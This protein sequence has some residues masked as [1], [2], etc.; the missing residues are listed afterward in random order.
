LKK[1][2][3]LAR[4]GVPPMYSPQAVQA[5]TEL[6][7]HLSAASA[8]L[9][10]FQQL[11][12]PATLQGNPPLAIPPTGQ[13][14]ALR[15]ASFPSPAPSPPSVYPTPPSSNYNHIQNHGHSYAS[16]S[17]LDESY[18]G[19]DTHIGELSVSREAMSRSPSLDSACCGGFLDCTEL[20]EEEHDELQEDELGPSSVSLVRTSGM[21]S[22][23]DVINRPA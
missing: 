6:L 20:V 19:R 9:S 2:L 23:S 14:H 15:P 13:S 12:F 18:R 16:Q 10:H 1:E 7:K 8:S 4:A 22:T 11:A 3:E 5:S 21:R 17:T